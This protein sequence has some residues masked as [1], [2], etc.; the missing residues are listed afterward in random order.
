MP[1]SPELCCIQ[2]FVREARSWLWKQFYPFCAKIE[3]FAFPHSD[4]VQETI[5]IIVIDFQVISRLQCVTLGLFGH[6]F[7]DS[8]QFFFSVSLVVALFAHSR[9]KQSSVALKFGNWITEMN[10]TMLH[11]EKSCS[12]RKKEI[13]KSINFYFLHLVIYWSVTVYF[14]YQTR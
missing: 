11:M 1:N 13:K 3:N 7:Y 9:R 12:G 5:I 14:L 10:K 4:I 2:C 8:T 6:T